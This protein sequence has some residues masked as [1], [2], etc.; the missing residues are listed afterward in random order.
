MNRAVFVNAFQPATEVDEPARF[1]GRREQV[2][3]LVEALHVLGSIPLIY[4]DRGLGKSSLSAQLARI[5]QGD[6]ELLEHLAMR[7]LALEEDSRFLTFSVTCTDATRDLTGLLQL[8]INSVEGLEFSAEDESSSSARKL[9]DRSTRRRVTLKIFESEVMKRYTTELRRR[10]YQQLGK[11]EQLIQLCD[12]LVDTYGQPVMFFVDEL[13]R[14]ESTAGL[15]SFLKAASRPSLKFTLIGI[16][17]VHSD[18]L[19]HQSVSRLLIPVRVPPMQRDELCEIVHQAQLFLSSQGAT[20]RFTDDAK[21]RLAERAEGFPWFV[22]VLGQAALLRAVDDGESVVVVADV[23]AGARALTANRFAQQ[24]NDQYQ[25]VVRDSITREITLRLFALWQGADIPTSAI[26]PLARSLGVT[27][28]SILKGHLC[29]AGYGAPLYTPAFQKRGLLR[30]RDRMFKTYICLRPSV[31][32]NV[33]E[34]VR[35]T[36]RQYH[37]LT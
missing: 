36:Y 37:D 23:E 14:L 21:E 16:A 9:V 8:C 3:D 25:N 4:G 32:A 29:S 7:H 28:P 17:S 30:F 1:A 34:E 5:A 35:N 15:A 31:Y 27:N 12:L 24:Y 20:V 2:K 26:Y 22:H 10:S 19:D 33:D 18:L 11:E 13:D 6:V